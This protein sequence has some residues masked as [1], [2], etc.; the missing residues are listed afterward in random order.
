[1]N[2]K[3]RYFINDIEVCK[4][5]Y[6]QY[7]TKEYRRTQANCKGFDCET[8]KVNDKIILNGIKFELRV[9]E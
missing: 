7:I 6:E 9:V 2:N 3:F 1:M 4:I 5:T 8:Y